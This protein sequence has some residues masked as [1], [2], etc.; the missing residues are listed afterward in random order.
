MFTTWKSKKNREENLCSSQWITNYST[1]THSLFEKSDFLINN[2]ESTLS[3][4]QRQKIQK[5]NK[6]ARNCMLLRED[7]PLIFAQ[8]IVKQFFFV[9]WQI[10]SHSDHGQICAFM[11]VFEHMISLFFLLTRHSDQKFIPPES[12]RT[13]ESNRTSLELWNCS[14][15]KY[16]F[17]EIVCI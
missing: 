7:C 15:K 8:L 5:P 1:N 14:L 2:I 17:R 6:S 13:W 9:K 10:M 11:S 12:N 4:S 16:L 3:F